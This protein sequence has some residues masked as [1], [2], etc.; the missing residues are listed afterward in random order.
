MIPFDC[1]SYQRK[2]LYFSTLVGWT[3][4]PLLIIFVI[5]ICFFR[6]RSVAETNDQRIAARNTYA[7]AILGLT[8]TIFV[9]ASA[10]VINFFNQHHFGGD[11]AGGCYLVM[12]YS[13]KCDTSRYN[14][15]LIYAAIMIFVCK[16]GVLVSC[17][18]RA[19]SPRLLFSHLRSNRNPAQLPDAPLLTLP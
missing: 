7:A 18:A 4:I 6:A 10:T 19:V 3:M 5:L 16:K 12:D 13:T 14:L 9:S 8:F 15:W 11:D 2:N 17:Q 1:F